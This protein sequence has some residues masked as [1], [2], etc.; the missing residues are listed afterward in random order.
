M[1]C[2]S[3]SAAVIS[4]TDDLPLVPTTWIEAKR[5]CGIP[6]TETS[7]RIRSRPKRQPERLERGEVA[8]RPSSPGQ[9]SPE[10]LELGPVARELLALRL[11][12]L[13]GRVGDEPL[14]RELALGALDLG[15]QR[16][17]AARRSGA[18]P[19]R[20]RPRP[21]RGSRPGRSVA[22]ASPLGA[23]EATAA[24]AAR[25]ARAAA[26]RSPATRAGS[27]LPG[28]DPDQVAPAPHAP[29]QLD[30]RLDLAL[31]GLVDQ[32]A[33]GLRERVDDQHLGPARRPRAGS[34]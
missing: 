34:E 2:A 14:V 5:C 9:R 3:S 25:P 33:V 26:R 1:P 30:R 24:P 19:G 16:A 27:T 12:H 10:L 20:R 13:G 4:A 7:R 11:D 15:A 29:R 32:R 21:R 17:R 6:S 28:G 23:V 18:G 31:G 8:P 22:S